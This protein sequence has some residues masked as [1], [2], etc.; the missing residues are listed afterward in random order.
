MLP[1][2]TDVIVAW[3]VCMCRLSHSFTLLKPMDGLTCHLA[4]TLVWSKV[5]LY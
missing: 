3:S 4:G 2:A 5:T 1:A